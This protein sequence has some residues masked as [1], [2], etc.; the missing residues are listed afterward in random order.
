MR[1]SHILALALAV[2]GVGLSMLPEAAAQSR[3]AVREQAEAAMVLT[4]QIDIDTEGQVE[5]FQLDKRDQVDDGIARFVEAAVQ[6]WQFEPVQVQG[7]AVPAR[8]PVS[9]RLGGKTTPDG[10]QQVTLLAAS[11]AKYDA[12]AVDQ[13]TKQQMR[14]PAYPE[15][16]YRV[17]G[18]GDVLLLVQVGRDGKVMDV[19]TEQV[20]LR[21][22]G[23]EAQ[24]RSMR[25]KLSRASM[26]AARKWTFNTPTSGALKDAENWTLRVPIHFALNDERERYGRWDAYIPGPRQQAPWRAD[27]ALGADANAD[28]LP[29]GGVFMADAAAQGPRLLTRLGG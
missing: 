16:V 12:D 21:V 7:R 2:G 4:G 11:F 8:T 17:R 19:A 22:V 26:A 13:V 24:M 27:Q 23:T 1:S 6:T 15:D 5:G 20:N 9:I 3:R 10:R 14:G 28:L 25:D 18:R 29:Q